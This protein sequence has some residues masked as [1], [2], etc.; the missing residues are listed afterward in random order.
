MSST[1]LSKDI[2]SKDD[3]TKIRQ[4]IEMIEAEPQAYDFLEPV[5]FISKNIF[6]I[7]SSWIGWLS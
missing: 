6:L 2:I 4:L 3:I 7:P 5:D 1:K